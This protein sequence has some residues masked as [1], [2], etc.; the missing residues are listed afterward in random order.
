LIITKKH[1]SKD[2]MSNAHKIRATTRTQVTT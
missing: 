1:R 2:G